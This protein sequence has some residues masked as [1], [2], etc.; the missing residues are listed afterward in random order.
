MASAFVPEPS[1]WPDWGLGVGWHCCG[2]GPS[3]WQDPGLGAQVLLEPGW[4]G[5]PAGSAQ[6]QILAELAHLPS[7][8]LS[9]RGMP[10]SLRAEGCVSHSPLC[11]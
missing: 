8:L 10:L 11:L 3:A 9:Q 4:E 1:S 6:G 7:V 2:P 5:L